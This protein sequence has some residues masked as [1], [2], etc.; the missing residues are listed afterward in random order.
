MEA[1]YW[2]GTPVPSTQLWAERCCAELLRL[3]Q[4]IASSNAWTL[5]LDMST[6][7]HCRREEPEAAAAKLFEP[8]K[9]SRVPW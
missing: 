1:R 9:P 5:S 8:V 6:E 2:P 4:L 3:D 7:G